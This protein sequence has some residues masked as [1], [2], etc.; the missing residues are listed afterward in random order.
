MLVL[1]RQQDEKGEQMKQIGKGVLLA[2]VVATISGCVTSSGVFSTGKDTFTI[3][4]TGRTHP[5][6]LGTLKKRAYAEANAYCEQQ[7]KVMQPI[8]TETT[9]TP[10]LNFEL[11]FRALDPNDPE[12]S[13]PTLEPVADTKIDVKVH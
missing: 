10:L 5:A 12:V 9:E 1:A 13:R 4:E 6:N 3:I 11:R 8:A 7:G 2:I